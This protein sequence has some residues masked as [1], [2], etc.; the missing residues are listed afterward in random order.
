MDWHHYI[1][2]FTAIFVIVDPLGAVPIFLS[3]TA[4]EN[5]KQ[6]A[7]T[8][9]VA[10]I[11]FA[12]AMVLATFIGEPILKFFGIRIASFQVG[13][14]ILILLLAISMLNAKI[15][16][17]RQTPE[18]AQEAVSKSNVAVVPLAIPLL[19]GPAAF[20]TVIIY[21]TRSEGWTD[22]AFI[23]ASIVLVA[24]IIWILFRLSI[25]LSH[26]LG[27]TGVN[28]VTRVM[29]LILAA[30]AIEFISAGMLQL[31]PALN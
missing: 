28:T 23:V 17:A 27:Q 5:A 10:A 29:G 12:I 2:I 6:R 31:F 8:A 9:L 4:D 1:E 25:P 3:V 13:G 14:G 15:S 24:L 7:R 30:I 18:E 16:P 20:S 21:S 22:R 26:R 19:S 11:V